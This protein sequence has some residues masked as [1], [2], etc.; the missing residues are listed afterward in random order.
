M[1]PQKLTSQQLSEL[2][3]IINSGDRAGYYIKYYEFTG[4]KASLEMAK[5]S[6][7][8][9]FLGGIAKKANELLS[10]EP[11]Y[12][13]EGVIKFSSEIA[14]EHFNNVLES[15]CKHG[16]GVLSDENILLAAQ[17]IWKDKDLLEKFPGN[18]KIALINFIEGFI[19]LFPN[20]DR[21]TFSDRIKWSWGNFTFNSLFVGLK[22]ASYYVWD[23]SFISAPQILVYLNNPD[24][25]QKKVSSDCK[26][27]YF[28]DINSSKIVYIAENDWVTSLND[29]L[30]AEGLSEEDIAERCNVPIT[31]VIEKFE[32]PLFLPNSFKKFF[33]IPIKNSI[34][35]EEDYSD[36]DPIVCNN[37]IANGT[38]I[39]NDEY[40]LVCINKERWF[41]ESIQNII[42]HYNTLAESFNKPSISAWNELP[43]SYHPYDFNR[44]LYFS[45]ID[46]VSNACIGLANTL[47]NEF[48]IDISYS[49]NYVRV[50]EK[51]I[52]DTAIGS[53][54]KKH[55]T[56]MVKLLLRHGVSNSLSAIQNSIQKGDIGVI[57]TLL[58]YG[59]LNITEIS[60]HYI[61]KIITLEDYELVK[62]LLNRGIN[63]NIKLFPRENGYSTGIK[64]YGTLLD[65]TINLLISTFK[66]NNED[67]SAK[68]F[69]IA[70]LLLEYGSDTN[71]PSSY[72]LNLFYES[73]L[74]SNS[75][76]FPLEKAVSENIPLLTKLLLESKAN[77]NLSYTDHLSNLKYLNLLSIAIEKGS[78]I[79]VNLLL[80]YGVNINGEDG[81]RNP[82]I[83]AIES[84]Q[85]EMVRTIIEHSIRTIH[86]KLTT[87]NL[88]KAVKTAADINST[89]S[90]NLIFRYYNNFYFD[91]ENGNCALQSAISHENAIITEIFI[92]HNARANGICNYYNTL[93]NSEYIE[94]NAIESQSEMAIVRA[95]SK[96]SSTLVK[97]LLGDKEIKLNLD[98]GNNP[99]LNAV[100]QSN[101]EMVETFLIAGADPNY[102]LFITISD[103]SW[104]TNEE[105]KLSCHK[106]ILDTAIIYNNTAI[107]K[108]LLQHGAN[109]NTPS[110]KS[111]YGGTCWWEPDNSYPLQKAI[112][113][114]DI[115]LINLLLSYNA[116]PNLLN[117]RDKSLISS[118]TETFGENILY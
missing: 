60:H 65:F 19:S 5:I 89:E 90:I 24:L 106:T 56:E 30:I 13:L 103:K 47:I 34:G 27:T 59:D 42:K 72:D 29:Y 61:I 44:M 118:I 36:M 15:Y 70:K 88:L 69:N 102:K 73:T 17:K 115:N 67:R 95:V 94:Y 92:K 23:E 20:D 3:S 111:L 84:M 100:K 48:N 83:Q 91:T 113:A 7:F 43:E 57:K 105:T 68:L 78:L 74:C 66:S 52:L 46:A 2:K 51:S 25:Y 54:N 55:K 53:Y 12:P 79:Q 110:L 87:S 33:V 63:T 37:E 64:C 41:N 116:D 58:Q 16:S 76:Y 28:K 77:P 109:P 6:S 82:I 93:I 38:I 81:N 39:F 26:V 40:E 86:S 35:T 62:V 8:S 31:N 22:G 21:Y 107:I 101:V 80:K 97:A 50:H 32:N 14:L 114:Y 104:F 98:N 117:A 9:G 11:N 49:N 96:N 108:L 4:S 71:T 85:I 45:F 1:I 112:E 18:S 75:K 10:V 99:L